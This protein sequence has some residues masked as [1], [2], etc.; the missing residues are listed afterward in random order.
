MEGF[1]MIQALS[2]KII[3]FFVINDIIS[4]NEDK[5]IYTYGLELILSAFLNVFIV[6]I[7]SLIIGRFIET[8]VFFLAF[9]PIR[10]YAGGYHAKTHLGCF[11]I[12]ML[13][14]SINLALLFFA[15]QSIVNICIIGFSSCSFILVAAFAPIEDSNKPLNSIEK[16]KFKKISIVIVAIQNIALF[17]SL[18]FFG[19]NNISF[20]FAIGQFAAAFSIAAV[21]ISKIKGDG[22]N[23]KWESLND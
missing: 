19:K 23:E 11:C 8:L 22:C 13:V 3:S 12:L 18:L 1:N 14:Y 15:P 7:F 2:D 6:L 20:G 10:T 17:L 16:T 4:D 21:K 5:S 9:I